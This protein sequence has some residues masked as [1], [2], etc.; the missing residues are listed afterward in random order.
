MLEIHN[1]SKKYSNGVQ[2]LDNVSLEIGKGMF[3]LLG[4]NGAGKSSLM[5][6]IA[7]LQ[8]ADAGNIT[9]NNIDI[10]KSPRELRLQLGYLPQEFGVYPKFSAFDLLDHMATLKGISDKK[11]RHEQINALLHQTN[12]FDARR[13]AVANFSG[14]MKQ[15][16][17]IAQALLGDPKLII[18]DEP[19]AGLDPEERNRFHN[20]LSEISENIIVLLST[21]I[22][23]D[24]EDLCTRMAILSGGKI[25]E[26]GH[27]TELINRLTGRVWMK[28]IGKAEIEPFERDYQVLSRQLHLG[29]IQARI[30]S[31]VCPED[32]FKCVTPTL[33]DVY[34]NTLQQG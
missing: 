26:C 1:L 24:V 14:G 15:R 29:K 4:P 11:Q 6:T 23:S 31:E 27:P 34:F 19:T 22:V 28:A 10:S 13:R 8:D 17:G 30:L 32:G 7:T 2:A 21:H 9:F 20:L 18:V 3:G 16:F 12:L 25:R 33:E 5:R